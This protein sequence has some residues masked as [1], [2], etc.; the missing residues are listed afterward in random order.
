MT[1]AKIHGEKPRPVRN[2]QNTRGRCGSGGGSHG[3]HQ[4]IDTESVTE[5]GMRPGITQQCRIHAH[6][7]RRAEPLHHAHSREHQKTLRQCATQRSQREK[8]ETRHI[9]TAVARNLAQR[10][11]RQKRNCDRKLITVDDPDRIG[12]V[13]IEIARDGGQRDIGDGAVEHRHENG[14][15]DGRHRPIA[16]GNGQTVGELL[17]LLPARR[18]RPIL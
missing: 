14:K 12:C 9:D 5:P 6:D 17:H 15:P 10:R 2:R 1:S 3:D 8:N 13:G 18:Q 11:Q 7:T 16:A 4:H